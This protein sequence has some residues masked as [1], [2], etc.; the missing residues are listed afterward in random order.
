MKYNNI[1][2]VLKGQIDSKVDA[3]WTFDDAK[4]EFT[5]IFKN[6]DNNL[7][8]Y[9]PQQLINYLNEKERA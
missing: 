8:I 7:S 4:Q 3:L 6:Y 1:K 2:K 9:T 5:M